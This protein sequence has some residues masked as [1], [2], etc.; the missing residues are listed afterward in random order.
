[1]MSQRDLS[2]D[3]TF[4]AKF[5]FPAFWMTLF[6]LLNLA[7]WFDIPHNT[8]KILPP[9]EMKFV[10][11]PVWILGSAFILWTNSGLKRVRTD[12][13]RLFISNYIQE[14]SVP[15]SAIIEVR[16]NRWLKSRPITVY[17]IEATEFGDRATFVPKWRF[18]LFWYED[19]VVDELRQ[20]ARL[21]SAF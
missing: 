3:W 6:G 17:F 18:R 4:L 2:S 1:M 9:P 5:V 13:H 8:N 15:F 10:F 19:P 7:L 21:A 16:Q 20:S 12:G 11:L 14:I